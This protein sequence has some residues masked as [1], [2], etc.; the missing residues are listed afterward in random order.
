MDLI[1]QINMVDI[2]TILSSRLKLD[3]F[4]NGKRN[5]HFEMD[6]VMLVVQVTTKITTS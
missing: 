6:V 2:F 5:Q 4:D 1:N 3:D